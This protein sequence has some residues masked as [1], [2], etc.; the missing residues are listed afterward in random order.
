MQ[1]LGQFGGQQQVDHGL[2]IGFDHVTSRLQP[3]H[4]RCQHLT[5]L[6]ARD[7]L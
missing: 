3:N 5:P 1:F 6:T 7:E 2:F 4:A